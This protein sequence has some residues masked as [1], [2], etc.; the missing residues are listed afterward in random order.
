M[1]LIRCPECK[2]KVSQFAEACPRC[3]FPIRNYEFSEK[4]KPNKNYKKILKKIVIISIILL[5]LIIATVISGQV[6]TDYTYR[7]QREIAKLERGRL[8][9]LSSVNS[10]DMYGLSNENNILGESIYEILENYEE[11][12]DY[13]VSSNEYCTTYTFHTMDNYESHGISGES[14]RFGDAELIVYESSADQLIDMFEYR[15]EIDTDN[16][17]AF[18]INRVKQALTDYY[19]VDPTYTYLDLDADENVTID[20]DMFYSFLLDDYKTIYHIDW[21][22]KNVDATIAFFNF[23]E[24]ASNTCSVIFSNN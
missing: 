4:T 23:N 2:K 8:F 24:E 9:Q 20:S 5:A 10:A 6:I 21:E 7:K 19:D 22:G 15:F 12:E 17:V 14:F 18:Q 16:H 13:T 3:G 1:T 11:G